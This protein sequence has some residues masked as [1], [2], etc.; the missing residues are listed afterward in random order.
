LLV[1]ADNDGLLTMVRE[2]ETPAQ[3][4][5]RMAAVDI[6]Q[7]RLVAAHI[8]HLLADSWLIVADDYLVIRNFKIFQKARNQSHLAQLLS[9]RDGS[10]M[11][12]RWSGDGRD[13]VE[14]WSKDGS[15]KPAKSLKTHSLE[16]EGDK[17]EK[18]IRIRTVKSSSAH[19]TKPPQEVFDYWQKKVSPGAKFDDR[20]KKKIT[21]RLKEK[22][23]VEQL[24]RV[25]DMALESPHHTG[26]NDRGR[27]YLDIR[28]IFRDAAQVEA[29][30]DGH[31]SKPTMTTKHEDLTPYEKR[32]R[33]ETAQRK[34]Q[35]ASGWTDKGEDKWN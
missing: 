18:E 24:K 25:I 13:M 33:K 11:V 32:K 20:R 14:T 31:H 22:F 35:E 34:R 8:N 30:L 9:A 7:R 15:R 27:K 16:I 10:D 5:C 17:R 12:E 1:H 19:S 6:S 3:A 23:T 26:A 2:S 28:T 29:F 4:F 21:A